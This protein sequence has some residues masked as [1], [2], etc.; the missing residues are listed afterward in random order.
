MTYIIRNIDLT[1]NKKANDSMK[2]LLVIHGFEA[3]C[4][5]VCRPAAGV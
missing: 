1:S 2:I 5:L 4:L 3:E